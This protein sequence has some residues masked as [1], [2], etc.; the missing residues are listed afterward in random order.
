MDRARLSLLPENAYVVNVGR[1]STIDQTALMNLLKDGRL[2]GA[3]L[4]VFDT[5]PPA[6][7]DPLWACPRLLITPHVAG[8]MMLDYTVDRVVGMFLKDFEHYCAGKP[9]ARQVDLGRGY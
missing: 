9:L 6:P 4:D 5:E 8:N 2:A 1:G 3:A 7:E